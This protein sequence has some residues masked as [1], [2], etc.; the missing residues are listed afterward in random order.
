MPVS[1]N[2]WRNQYVLLWNNHQVAFSFCVSM[3]ITRFG[4]IG[5][6]GL[7]VEA[8]SAFLHI[9]Q[10]MLIYGCSKD[11][12]SFRAISYVNLGEA[13]TLTSLACFSWVC[14][15]YSDTPVSADLDLDQCDCRSFYSMS[16]WRNGLRNSVDGNIQGVLH[17]ALLRDCCVRNQ[18]CCAAQRGTV[19]SL[20]SLRHS[21]TAQAS[22]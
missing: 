18:H 6:A 14:T 2:R 19:L 8:S 21:S 3:A 11:T 13:M 22:T 1:F 9:R 4:G 7:V 16:V 15:I 10:L 5:A 20:V 17:V 12:A